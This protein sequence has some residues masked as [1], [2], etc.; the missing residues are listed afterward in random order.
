MPRLA[1]GR[2][3]PPLRERD[4][5]D[6]REL[7]NLP[8][9]FSAELIESHK[10]LF[11]DV[12]RFLVRFFFWAGIV[13][14]L[15]VALIAGLEMTLP[16]LWSMSLNQWRCFVGFVTAALLFLL[17]WLSRIPDHNEEAL[18]ALAIRDN[19]TEAQYRKCALCHEECPTVGMLCCGTA[20]HV[21]C[22]AKWL[23][24]SQGS[25]MVC[26]TTTQKPDPKNTDDEWE[27]MEE[28]EELE[29]E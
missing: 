15:G 3:P 20:V 10:A 9:L 14:G 29:D 2:V 24:E 27:D 16:L 8:N 13:V 21:E 26:R 28:D 12:G 6:W 23:R 7:L 17:G 25:C 19:R 22:L 5:W 1:R 18:R 4:N 11:C